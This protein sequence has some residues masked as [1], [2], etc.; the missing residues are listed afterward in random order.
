MGPTASTADLEARLQAATS[1]TSESLTSVA[2]QIDSL[3]RGYST[4]S[5]VFVEEIDAV[6]SE[7]STLR[8]QLSGR[9]KEI[10]ALNESF[11]KAT[12][13]HQDLANEVSQQRRYLKK[14]KHHSEKN[15]Q[16]L[17]K[18][19][20]NVDDMLSRI[21]FLEKD[22]RELWRTVNSHASTLDTVQSELSQTRHDLREMEARFQSTLDN[23]SKKIQNA[24]DH[25]SDLD[26]GFQMFWKRFEESQKRIGAL[27]E[28]V[29][30]VTKDSTQNFQQVETEVSKVRTYTPCLYSLSISML[31]L[32]MRLAVT[33]TN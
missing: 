16:E 3:R 23:H 24:S 27:A 7:C 22:Q 4:L 1:A 2:S 18:I 25:S 20:P 10:D 19:Q 8:A 5:Q 15:G 9:V 30:A 33:L 28:D 31:G 21:S 17:E 11:S 13:N 32:F 14:V 29:S 6:R 26:Q 12:R